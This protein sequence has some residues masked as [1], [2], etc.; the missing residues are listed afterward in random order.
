MSDDPLDGM[1]RR[2]E[3][4]RRLARQMLDQETIDALLQMAEEIEID[5]AKLEAERAGRAGPSMPNPIPPTT[6]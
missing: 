5:L 1:R 4:C 6:N 2:I 3:T